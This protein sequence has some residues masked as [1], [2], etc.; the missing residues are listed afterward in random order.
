[1]RRPNITQSP[2]SSRLRTS[3]WRAAA[4][5]LALRNTRVDIDPAVRAANRKVDGAAGTQDLSGRTAGEA[6]LAQVGIDL[7]VARDGVI[8]L[9]TDANRLAGPH[10]ASTVREAL[11]GKGTNRSVGQGA[12]DGI[13]VLT[14]R[15]RG[16]SIAVTQE[17][18]VFQM[19][20][21][22][23]DIDRD[24]VA[25]VADVDLVILI[26]RGHSCAQSQGDTRCEGDPQD[27]REDSPVAFGDAQ[28]MH[29]CTSS[30]QQLTAEAHR[31]S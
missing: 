28:L 19:R 31:A 21:D 26:G 13:E 15:A 24:D 12:G 6:R 11:V 17:I 9:A 8:D 4:L 22:R 23:M 16:R 5:P 27:R 29:C 20:G 3:E 1:M 18:A 25:I 14:A 30:F 2:S 10:R 7:T